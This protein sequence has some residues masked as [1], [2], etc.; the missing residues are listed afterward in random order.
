MTEVVREVQTTK[1]D[2][3]ECQCTFPDCNVICVVNLFYAPYK[4]RCSSHKGK[5]SRDI[6]AKNVTTAIAITAEKDAIP[7]G[8]LALLLC[9]ICHSKM[10]INQATSKGTFITFVCAKQGQC[11]TVIEV[12]LNWAWGVVNSIPDQWKPLFDAHNQIVKEYYKD[13]PLAIHQSV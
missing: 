10:T 3:K 5:T 4:A 6:L 12:K 9:P 2:T 1:K 8:A 7:N 13:L 11:G